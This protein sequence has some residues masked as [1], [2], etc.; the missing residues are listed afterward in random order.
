MATVLLSEGIGDGGA[1]VSI[2]QSSSLP[3]H[4]IDNR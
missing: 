2:S 1:V 3:F 4:E